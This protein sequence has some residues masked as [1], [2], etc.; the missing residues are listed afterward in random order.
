MGDYPAA[1]SYLQ[2]GLEQFRDLGDR[3]GQAWALHGLGH[4]QRATGDYRAASASF[5][6]V[7]RLYQ[8]LG[9]QHA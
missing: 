2:Q 6:Q 5:S 8:D 9:S 4:L 7:L 1:A 3:L